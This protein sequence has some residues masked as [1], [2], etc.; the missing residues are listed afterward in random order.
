[1]APYKPEQNLSEVT[2]VAPYKEDLS[3]ISP[4]DKNKLEQNLSEVTDVKGPP[5]SAKHKRLEKNG[6]E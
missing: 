5:P 2:P 3:E 4:V 6:F 1:M